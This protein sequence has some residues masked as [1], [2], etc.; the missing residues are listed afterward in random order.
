MKR[1]ASDQESESTLFTDFDVPGHDQK[2]TR[3]LQC[4]AGI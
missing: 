3:E 2:V 4:T 1:V